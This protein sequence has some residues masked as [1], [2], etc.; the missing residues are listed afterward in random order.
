MYLG[1]TGPGHSDTYDV[2]TDGGGPGLKIIAAAAAAEYVA[3]AATARRPYTRTSLKPFMQSH[4][5][6]RYALS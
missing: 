2:R 1:R 3:V 4:K 6:Y 5:N